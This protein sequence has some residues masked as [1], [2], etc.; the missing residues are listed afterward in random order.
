VAQASKAEE[1]TLALPSLSWFPTFGSWGSEW[2][3][4]LVFLIV[5]GHLTNTC[6]SLYLHRCQAH[7]SVELH[8]FA[9]LCMRVWLW[10][11][12][13]IKTREWVGC[14]R[15]HHAFSDRDGDPHSPLREGLNN[16]LLKGYFYYRRAVRQAGVVEKYGAGTPTD[17]FERH[18]F[19]RLHWLGLAAMLA[20]DGYL[21]GPVSGSLV[22]LGQ[23]LWVPFWAAGI[24]NG[25]G[26]AAGYRNFEIRGASHNIVPLAVWLGGEELHNNHHADP[27]SARFA[28]RWF[29]FDI[30]WTYL[31]LLSLFGL[32][33]V[34]SRGRTD[35]AAA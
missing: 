10:L 26:H 35:S 17:W 28:A 19:D 15:K 12:T 14:H 8:R 9:E 24:V 2:W 7:G 30:G 22:W 18:L 16:V 13:S 11:S 25:L 34:R 1:R 5:A 6:I 29:E 4:P 20:L 21:F 23:L 3:C 33:R 27:A 32:V 31:R